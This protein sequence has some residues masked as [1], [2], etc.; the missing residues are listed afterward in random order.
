MYFLKLKEKKTV[1]SHLIQFC[2]NNETNFRGESVI[3]F[4]YLETQK[5]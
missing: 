2:I 1:K 3:F 4:K 5:Y